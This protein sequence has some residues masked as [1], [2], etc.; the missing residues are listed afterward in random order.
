M[1][2]ILDL[3]VVTI[4]LLV[5]TAIWTIDRAISGRSTQSNSVTLVRSFVDAKRGSR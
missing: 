3:G 2:V 4:G 1:S 5:A